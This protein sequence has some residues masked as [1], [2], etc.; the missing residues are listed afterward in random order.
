V[1]W[2]GDK[3]LKIVSLVRTLN[4]ERNIAKFCTA[5]SFS[6]L[7]LVADGGST[8]DTV[9]IAQSFP[10][11]KVRYFT[12][13]VPGEHGTWRN[14]EGKH[15]NFLIDWAN[16]EK[17]DWM[18]FEDCDCF[19]TTSLQR[20]A[21]DFFE[22]T[23]KEGLKCIKLQRIYL[24]EK[25]KWFSKCQSNINWAWKPSTGIRADEQYDW[26]IVTLNVPETGYTLYPPYAVL[27][28][29]APTPE[30]GQA[31]IDFY[32]LTNRMGTFPSLPEIFGEL[33]DKLDWMK[34]D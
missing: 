5:Y 19:P 4:E 10:N 29:F 32:N 6:D 16:E 21:R 30:I 17:C 24:Y 27:H 8:D 14:P 31:K 12:D 23:D 33:G 3:T 2:N 22:I 26:G 9:E 1:G 28:D 7:V 34:Y 20:K 15:I 13:I 11:V 18:T 25:D